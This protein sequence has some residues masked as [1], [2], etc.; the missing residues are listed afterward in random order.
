[1]ENVNIKALEG[2]NMEPGKVYKV[3]EQS[4]DFLVKVKRAVLA[5]KNEKV[6]KVYDYPKAKKSKSKEDLT[7]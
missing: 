4:G 2:T 1:M 7:D 5:D 6:G 3:S